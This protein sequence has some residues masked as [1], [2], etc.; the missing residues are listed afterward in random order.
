M[1]L[2]VFHLFN[3]VDLLGT[4]NSIQK[5]GTAMNRIE[6]VDLMCDRWHVELKSLL[7]TQEA[8][9]ELKEEGGYRLTHVGSIKRADNAL[10]SGKDAQ[11]CLRA[12]PVWVLRTGNRVL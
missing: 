9:K 2:L 5:D 10:F 3:F 6:H 8:I 12:A 4:R 1:S 11:E 7:S